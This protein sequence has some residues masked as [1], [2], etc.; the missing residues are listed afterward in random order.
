MLSTFCVYEYFKQEFLIFISGY[1]LCDNS[2]GVLFNDYTRLIMYADGDSLQ[3]IDKTATESY[4]SVRSFP[5]TLNK[6]V[7]SQT[8]LFCVWD[9]VLN[10]LRP[11]F[12]TQ[13][14]VSLLFV[15]NIA[16]ILPQLHER[17]P[18]EG[19]RKHSTSGRRWAGTT[20]VPF[21]LVQN[22]KRHC[23]APH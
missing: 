13:L 9:E 22:Q 6:K 16:E 10:G 12:H 11:R 20:A 23:A 3:Y 18:A 1:Q 7:R 21:P 5:S 2:V 15:D 17:A 14:S 8:F 19:W 4:T